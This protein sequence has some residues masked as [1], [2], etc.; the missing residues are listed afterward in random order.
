MHIALLDNYYAIIH[1]I[2]CPYCITHQFHL[3][4]LT[5]MIPVDF[6]SDLLAWSSGVEWGRSAE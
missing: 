4:M 3:Q 2:R 6:K 1:V 5:H